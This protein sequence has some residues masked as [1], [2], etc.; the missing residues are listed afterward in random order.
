[1]LACNLVDDL[2]GKTVV[3]TCCRNLSAAT[4]LSGVGERWS[5]QC[6]TKL[7]RSS[8]WKSGASKP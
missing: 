2:A 7:A 3:A 5:C 8:R 4:Y 6:A 1:M